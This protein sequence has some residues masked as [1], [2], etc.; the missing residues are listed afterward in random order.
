VGVK[1][2]MGV[3]VLGV[4][5]ACVDKAATVSACCVY[6]GLSVAAASSS[7]DERWHAGRMRVTKPT[8]SIVSIRVIR[9]MLSSFAG[10]CEIRSN[11]FYNKIVFLNMFL[12]KMTNR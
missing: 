8:S 4:L 2:A 7:D 3:G 6:R 11:L 1:T 5:A 10:L 9:M 12:A